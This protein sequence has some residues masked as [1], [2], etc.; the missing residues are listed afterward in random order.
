MKKIFTIVVLALVAATGLNAQNWEVAPYGITG[1]TVNCYRADG[2]SFSFLS[3]MKRCGFGTKIGVL[4]HQDNF[5]TATV[6]YVEDGKVVKTVKEQFVL[7]RATSSENACPVS[8][9]TCNKIKNHL[10]NVGDII[11]TLPCRNDETITIVVSRN[12]ELVI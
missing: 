9:E 2:C 10:K 7:C 3:G 4:S 12:G 1:K 8:I 5:L 6:S 11:V